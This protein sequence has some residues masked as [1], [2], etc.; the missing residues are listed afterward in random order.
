MSMRIEYRDQQRRK[1]GRIEADSGARATRLPIIEP[2]FHDP[3]REAFLN[4][5]GAIDDA[6]RLRKCVA[7]G[8]P[9]LFREKAF[10][11]VTGLVV[12]MAFA[13]AIAGVLGLA[14]NLPAL[15][16]LTG[17]LTLDV[18]ILVFSHR[19]LV[20]YRCRSSYHDLPIARYHRAWDRAVAE[21][22]PPSD[23]PAPLAPLV[24]RIT[25]PDAH[26]EA[27]ARLSAEAQPAMPATQRQPAGVDAN[28]RAL[29]ADSFAD[30][31][32]IP[33]EHKSYFA[34]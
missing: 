34:S 24:P 15:L 18:A 26:A 23:A 12:V 13:G 3:Q 14:N 7:C 22:Y 4:W 5:E 6:G 16:G 20:C 1:I 10:P 19:R 21:R 27:L 32:E 29:P 30:S 11:Q 33:L 28:D 17:L 2:G 25:A 9:E 31:D 8:C